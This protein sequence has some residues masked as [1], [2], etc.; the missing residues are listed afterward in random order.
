MRWTG[1]GTRAGITLGDANNPKTKHDSDKVADTDTAQHR[2]KECEMRA[3]FPSF[4]LGAAS[5]MANQMA[6]TSVLNV[7][8]CDMP[9]HVP[10]SS[11]A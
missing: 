2:R 3:H 10:S 7:A 4:A 5:H 6:P 11:T 1:R 8:L 9:A